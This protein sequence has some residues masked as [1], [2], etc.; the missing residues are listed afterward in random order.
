VYVLITR[1][2]YESLTHPDTHEGAEFPIVG[3]VAAAAYFFSTIGTNTSDFVQRLERKPS[4]QDSS[5]STKEKLEVDHVDDPSKSNILS[6][7]QLERLAQRM[8]HK[9]YEKDGNDNLNKA[10]VLHGPA[11]LHAFRDARRAE[12]GRAHQIASATV[13]Y[14]GDLTKTGLKSKLPVRVTGQ[15]V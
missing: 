6:S 1:D 5:E 14:A 8:A 15:F 7:A 11:R 4:Q 13:H 2:W 9:I 3:A 12:R 10:P